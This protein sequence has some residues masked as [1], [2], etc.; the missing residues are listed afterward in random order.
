MKTYRKQVRN[1]LIIIKSKFMLKKYLSLSH[2]ILVGI[3][4]GL[5]ILLSQIDSC[6]GRDFVSQQAKLDSLTL[7]NQQ[8][9]QV[10]NSL[11]QTISKQAVIIT[12]DQSSLKDLTDSLFSLNKR[13]QKRV[14]KIDA[15]I[16]IASK[17]HVDTLE[18][19]YVD[20]IERKRFSDSLERIC[21]DVID[22]YR[23][24]TV[25]LTDST[26][27]ELSKHVVID[28]IENKHFQ[29][30]GSVLKNKFRINSVNFPDSQ[31][32]AIIETKGGFFKR[33]IN[34]K[35]K[36]FRKK[37][38]EIQVLHTNPYIKVSGMSSIVYKPPVKGRWVERA[39]L[40]GGGI[41]FKI[42]I[43]K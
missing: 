19:A 16:Q 10:K 37:S 21:A 34:G 1:F 22:Y 2:L 23:N 9:V 33:D 20:T 36:I 17:T 6:R 11:N 43:L 38:M 28:S 13:D 29:F 15:L 12:Q 18:V 32:I 40:F 26:N 8:L 25:E 31:R 35:V 39:L 3:I 27:G 14:K 24:T 4:I 41:A 7:A 30:D 42:F 5:V